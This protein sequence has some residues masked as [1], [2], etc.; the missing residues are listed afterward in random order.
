MSVQVKGANELRARL[1]RAGPAILAEIASTVSAQ[2][3]VVLSAA[4]M[5]VPRDH[6]ALASSAF[7]SGPEM[8][9]K[10]L[11][12][13]ATAGYDAKYAPFEHEGFHYGK[14]ST[15][16]PKWLEHAAHAQESQFVAAVSHA[17]REGLET[18]GK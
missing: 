7:T 1:R 13:I 16:P 9:D 18:L 10:A 8:N 4:Q 11:S 5:A 15:H 3:S 6:G 12:V 17:I 2:A 14:R